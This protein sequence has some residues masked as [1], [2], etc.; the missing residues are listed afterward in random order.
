MSALRKYTDFRTGSGKSV[1]LK[2]SSIA[3]AL[4]VLGGGE[5]DD[6]GACSSLWFFFFILGISLFTNPKEFKLLSD[7]FLFK[8]LF[9]L[10]DL[11][12]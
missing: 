11:A 4:A 3:K 8:Y 9:I 6:D 5:D 1:A 7:F 10:L 2:Q 12:F